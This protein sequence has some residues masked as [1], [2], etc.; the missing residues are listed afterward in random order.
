MRLFTAWRHDLVCR[1]AVALM[2]DYLEDALS[3]S[4]RARLERHLAQC[5]GCDE[6]LRQMRETIRLLGRIEP[7]DLS[8][9]ARDEIVR[10]SSGTA[11]RQVRTA[12]R[13]LAAA[14]LGTQYRRRDPSLRDEPHTRRSW[15]D[16]TVRDP[17]GLPER[18][19]S[20]VSSAESVRRWLGTGGRGR[21]G[22]QRA[23]AASAAPTQ[24]GQPGGGGPCGAEPSERP[25]RSTILR[26]RHSA[27][28]VLPSHLRQLV[29]LCR[30]RC[31]LQQSQ[32]QLDRAGRHLR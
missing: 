30:H 29:R 28:A 7:D 12:K 24:T 17:W 15:R 6:Y 25:A 20:Y 11:K 32:L 8:L 22:A 13:T 4:N 18:R 10:S 16:E 5:D 14:P 2:T 3:R 1:D 9:E 21:P 31:R 26:V 27:S 19:G 23:S